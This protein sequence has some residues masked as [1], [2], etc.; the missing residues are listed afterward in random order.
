M[1]YQFLAAFVFS[2]FIFQTPFGYSI[3]SY[4][5]QWHGPANGN[6]CIPEA[7]NPDIELKWAMNLLDPNGDGNQADNLGYTAADAFKEGTLVR[8]DSLWIYLK[9]NRDYSGAA[10]KTLWK[11]DPSDG[12]FAWNST[13]AN[14]EDESTP[15]AFQL[16]RDPRGH[17]A[18]HVASFYG[19]YWDTYN[20]ETQAEENFFQDSH[21]CKGSRILMGKWAWK[22]NRFRPDY[23]PSYYHGGTLRFWNGIDY[24]TI[25]YADSI[26]VM[27]HAWDS[28]R[29]LVAVLSGFSTNPALAYGKARY[30]M[31]DTAGNVVRNDTVSGVYLPTCPTNWTSYNTDIFMRLALKGDYLYAIERTTSVENQLVRRRIS[32][33]CI[34]TDSIVL[35][36]SINDRGTSIALD[37][38]A[39]YVQRSG[40][41][42]AYSLDLRTVRWSTPTPVR[43][44]YHQTIQVFDY[45]RFP[46]NRNTPSQTLACN[47]TWVYSTNDS[48]LQIHRASNGELVDEHV[49]DDL[50]DYRT[51]NG[52]IVYGVPG[53][54]VLMPGY[55][56]VVSCRDH[57]KIWVFHEASSTR[58]KD[59]GTIDDTRINLEALPNPFNPDLSILIHGGKASVTIHDVRGNH[60]KTLFPSSSAG[61]GSYMDQKY[62][63][64]AA[65]HPSGIYII[66]ARIGRQTVLK[67]I[68]LVK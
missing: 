63:W 59:T 52:A 26:A 61:S 38:N 49:F 8:A 2:V 60:L 54:I 33:G 62:S 44:T 29:C 35:G 64:N 18:L 48:S 16:Y 6:A 4:W 45:N 13:K 46:G 3:D 12:S 22:N 55:V 43:T 41:I 5:G 56:V 40:E 68:M 28:S 20:A 34:K 27:D 39:I 17:A 24:N 32:M 53:D 19:T 67:R 25:Q 14:G 58:K 66:K 50:P 11:I 37:D 47:G 57:S 31:L 23:S 42:T 30:L 36:T 7:P 51:Y 15:R 65:G 21:S 10:D 9:I 1:R